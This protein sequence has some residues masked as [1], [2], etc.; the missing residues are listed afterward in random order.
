MAGWPALLRP[1]LMPIFYGKISIRL[2]EKA[3]WPA[4]RDPGLSCRDHGKP[5]C[6]IL[7]INGPARF[8][9][10]KNCQDAWVALK[11]Q[12]DLRFAFSQDYFCMFCLK[13]HSV[14]A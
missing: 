1:R 2:Y 13:F 5:G 8:A 3:A 11:T 14:L 12:P 4:C 9:R 6:K 7:I 10:M